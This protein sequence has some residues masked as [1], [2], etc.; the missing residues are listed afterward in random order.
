MLEDKQADRQADAAV[1]LPCSRATLDRRSICQARSSSLGETLGSAREILGS[2]VQMFIGKSFHAPTSAESF[3]LLS[4]T[5]ETK[6]NAG[7]IDDRS[8]LFS[9][10]FKFIRF[11]NPDPESVENYYYTVLVSG[12]AGKKGPGAV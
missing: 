3:P 7:E 4:S 9:K 5:P 8:K 6:Q 1:P 11:G 2:A 12:S 10:G